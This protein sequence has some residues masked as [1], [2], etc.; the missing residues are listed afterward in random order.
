MSGSERR[1]H[2]APS[3]FEISELCILGLSRAMR[4]R[5]PRDHTMNAFIGRLMRDAAAANAVLDVAAVVD[6]EVASAAGCALPDTRRPSTSDGEEPENT[7]DACRRAALSSSR[8]LH[9]G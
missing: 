6:V 3:R 8:D 1:F 7:A 2:S 9:S 4:R 5:W